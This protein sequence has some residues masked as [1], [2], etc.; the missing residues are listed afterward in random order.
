MS[1]H[2]RSSMNYICAKNKNSDLH[3]VALMK[4]KMTRCP[5]KDT[6]WNVHYRR[7]RSDCAPRSLISLCLEK[8]TT[9]RQA[10]NKD[11]DQTADAQTDFSLR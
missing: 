2:V 7:L 6:S 8:S 11:Y 4:V 10:E 1:T 9:F 3:S 5:A